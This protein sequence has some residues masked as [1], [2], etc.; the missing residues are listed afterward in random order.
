MN[1]RHA[2]D[3]IL[4]LLADGPFRAAAWAAANGAARGHGNADG[5][6]RLPPEVAAVVSRLDLAGL[7]RFARFLCRHYYRERVVHYFKYCRALA[8]WTGRAPETA[9]KTPEFT[10]LLPRLVLGDRG[11]AERVLELLRRSLTE[12]ADAIRSKIPYWSDLV[13]YQEAFFLSDALPPERFALPF[14][15]RAETATILELA[16]DLPAVLPALLRPFTEIPLPREQP[17]RLLFAR[18]KHGEVTVLRCTDALKKLLEGLTGDAPPTEIAARLGLDSA[19][20][21]KTLR[22]L[23]SLGAVL[24]QGSFSSSHV[25]SDLPPSSAPSTV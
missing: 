15:A 16:W 9:L 13:A 4:R 1:S 2:Q 12:N 25:G 11:S 7:D 6:H 18:S 22:Q 24:A 21:D 23:E 5:R 17:T 10:A 20:L 19:A 8:P 14:P 3:V